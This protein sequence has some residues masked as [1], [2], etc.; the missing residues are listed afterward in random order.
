MCLKGKLEILL[1]EDCLGTSSHIC[2]FAPGGLQRSQQGLR[3]WLQ[4]C[5]QGLVFSWK[6]SRNIGKCQ[7]IT[8][9]ISTYIYIYIYIYVCVLY[10]CVHI[11]TYIYILEIESWGI[12][13]WLSPI[14]MIM[15]KFFQQLHEVEQHRS[16]LMVPGWSDAWSGD[17]FII[18]LC[19]LGQLWQIS[20]FY[21]CIILKWNILHSKVDKVELLAGIGLRQWQSSWIYQ[22]G[23][24]C[25]RLRLWGLWGFAES[26]C[27]RPGQGEENG[28]RTPGVEKG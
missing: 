3:L 22:L 21:I 13:A 24:S 18:N 14:H 8:I 10:S 12:R 23:W 11:Y 26:R 9:Y 28:Y 1:Q 6:I 17:W 19:D 25:R 16:S 20:F 27:R 7:Y 4:C 5:H 2:Q 15:E